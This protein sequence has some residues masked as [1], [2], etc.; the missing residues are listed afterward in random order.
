VLLL[1]GLG[2]RLLLAL[3]G[4]TQQAHED[5]EVRVVTDAAGSQRSAIL[6]LLAAKQHTLLLSGDACK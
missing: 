3:L 1:L 6:Q 5:V 2:V 4:T